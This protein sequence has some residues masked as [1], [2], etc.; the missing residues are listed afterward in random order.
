MYVRPNPKQMCV[1]VRVCMCVRACVY[2]QIKHIIRHQ[3]RGCMPRDSFVCIVYLL[4]KI[5]ICVPGFS[6]LGVFPNSRSSLRQ[7]RQLVVSMP[8]KR[9][10]AVRARVKCEYVCNHRCPA[11]ACVKCEYVCN[12]RCPAAACVSVRLSSSTVEGCEFE[13]YY[14]IAYQPIICIARDRRRLGVP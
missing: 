14:L 8:S 1:C 5:A 2:R 3:F 9:P 12:H 4:G 11:A 6:V 10:R 13:N 7:L